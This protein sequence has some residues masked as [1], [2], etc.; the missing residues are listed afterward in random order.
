MVQNKKRLLQGDNS[1]KNEQEKGQS[2]VVNK[3][4]PTFSEIKMQIKDLNVF[5][6]LTINNPLRKFIFWYENK[7]TNGILFKLYS[8][9]FAIYAFYIPLNMLI[10]HHV[11]LISIWLLFLFSIYMVI[12]NWNKV[13]TSTN[14]E[15]YLYKKQDY[16]GLVY[17]ICVL[18]GL[19]INK[20]QLP[21]QSQTSPYWEF[22]S[23]Q[24][25]EISYVNYAIVIGICSMLIPD[26]SNINFIYQK[27]IINHHLKRISN[28]VL[29][30][31]FI[32]IPYLTIVLIPILYRNIFNSESILF[33]TALI[34]V[35]SYWIVALINFLLF[36]FSF[37]LM[38]VAKF[39]N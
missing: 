39:I 19:L 6:Q 23:E 16:I 29:F 37:L 20:Y 38:V 34:L 1:R 13:K 27:I 35:I 26:F 33:Q 8:I 4:H 12:V 17:A 15:D 31:V 2:K 3:K 10:H 32:I 24:L 9:L 5:E 22:F 11:S 18:V 7:K 14:L 30:L 25:N 21:L 28:T 36:L